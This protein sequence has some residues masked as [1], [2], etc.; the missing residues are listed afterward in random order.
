MTQP[1]YHSSN[2]VLASLYKQLR[3]LIQGAVPHR[4]A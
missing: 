3:K 2:R 1:I 4:K